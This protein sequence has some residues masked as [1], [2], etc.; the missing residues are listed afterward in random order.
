MRK[1]GAVVGITAM[2]IYVHYPDR[3]ALLNAVADEGFGELAG[4]LERARLPRGVEARMGKL[5]ELYVGYALEHPRMF[6]LM[7]L[8]PRKGARKYPQDFKAGRSPTANLF[9]PVLQEAMERG[10]LRRDDPWEIM[11][12]LGALLEGLLMLY[13]GGRIDGGARELRALVRRS[14]GRYVHGIA[15]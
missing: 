8:A 3:A 9:V 11:F 2:A 4:A 6:E 1:V 12:E 13:L 14:I 5:A 10:E 7:F 15:A